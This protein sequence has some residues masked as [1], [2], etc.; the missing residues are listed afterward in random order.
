M[1]EPARAKGGRF[2][3]KPAADH[4]PLPRFRTAAAA[5][6]PGERCC[7][8]CTAFH[9]ATR[10]CRRGPPVVVQVGLAEYPVMRAALV[11]WCRD[12]FES[13]RNGK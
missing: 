2:A 6:A 12:G 10:T 8:N 1:N 11:E 5:A 9:D 4:E 13:R 7:A 3:P